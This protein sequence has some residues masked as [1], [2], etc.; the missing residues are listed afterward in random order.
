MLLL[1]LLLLLILSGTWSAAASR[2]AMYAGLMSGEKGIGPNPGEK[3]D[4]T[5]GDAKSRGTPRLLLLLLLLL[6]SSSPGAP[7]LRSA[8]RTQWKSPGAS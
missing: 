6:L 3:M 4:S 5:S 7:A 2:P 1:L 8:G